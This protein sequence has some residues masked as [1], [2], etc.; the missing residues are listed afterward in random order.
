MIDYH[1]AHLLANRLLQLSDLSTML[2]TGTTRQ[3]DRSMQQFHGL[4]EYCSAF[5]RPIR[6][7]CKIR[8][9]YEISA[10]LCMYQE[11]QRNSE[12]VIMECCG[13]LDLALL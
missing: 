6:C 7:A 11:M 8:M 9:P 5:T 12:G 10:K 4:K 3:P 1:I 2:R 13:H